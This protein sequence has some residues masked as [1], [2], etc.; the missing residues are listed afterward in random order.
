MITR[1]MPALPAS[2]LAAIA[3]LVS[4]RTGMILPQARHCD[5]EMAAH[6]LMSRN[7]VTSPEAFVDDLRTDEALLEDLIGTVTVAETYFFRE[8][9]QFAVIR[10]EVIPVL[11]SPRDGGQGIRVWSAGCATGEEAY[12]LAIVF[13]QAGLAARTSILA[14]DISRQALARARAAVYGAWSFR[15]AGAHLARPYL[16]PVGGRFRLAERLRRRVTFAFL[17]LAQDS[18]PA[19]ATNTQGMDIITCRNVLIYLDG[20]TVC[21]V[22]QRFHAA[23]APGGLLFTGP[24]DPILSSH[25]PFETVMTPSGLVYRK[26]AATGSAARLALSSI[27]PGIEVEAETLPEP[28]AAEAAEPIERPVAYPRDPLVEARRVVARRD[29]ANAP[30]LAEVRPADVSAAALGLRATAN[31]GDAG[32]AATAAAALRQHPLSQELGFLH[33]VLLFDQGLLGEAERALKRLLYVDSSLAV[34]QFLL[35]T[36]LHRMGNLEGAERAFRNARDMAARR[37]ADEIVALSEGEQAG[38]LAKAAA[39]QVRMV[40]RTAAEAR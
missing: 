37:P 27:S 19:A 24:S 3:D 30:W 26:P 2:E 33:A 35:G 38:R 25:A 17:N 4:E 16:H 12:S 15:G 14:T 28:S 22:A 11:Q 7:N 6:D 36:T 29:D 21:D 39:A 18:Y 5:L 13:E 32:S 10:D 40:R 31:R 1:R 9:G 8:P 23:L 20:Q 34:A